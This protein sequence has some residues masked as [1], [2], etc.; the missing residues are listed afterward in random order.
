[1]T[2]DELEAE[3]YSPS[4]LITISPLSSPEDAREAIRA[5]YGEYINEIE[6][7]NGVIW[8]SLLPTGPIM[9]TVSRYEPA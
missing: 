2:S 6:V 7:I 5:A 4:S 1:M 9:I 3:I 8:I